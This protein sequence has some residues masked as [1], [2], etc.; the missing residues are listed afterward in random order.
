MYSSSSGVSCSV[1]K[2]AEQLLTENSFE[3]QT[4]RRDR[5][6]QISAKKLP[7]AFRDAN[8]CVDGF[9]SVGDEGEEDRRDSVRVCRGFR[10]RQRQT[11]SVMGESLVG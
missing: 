8:A 3:N 1:K 9:K 6:C 11:E 10:S 7:A 5:G 2:F 4:R